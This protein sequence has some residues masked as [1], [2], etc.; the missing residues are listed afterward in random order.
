MRL[1]SYFI[2]V[3]YLLFSHFRREKSKSQKYGSEYLSESALGS[4]S[5]ACVTALGQVFSGPQAESL[6]MRPTMADP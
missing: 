2:P 6:K 1:N 4:S 5:L 3:R